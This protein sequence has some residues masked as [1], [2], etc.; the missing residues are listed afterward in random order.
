MVNFVTVL[1]NFVNEEPVI[2]FCFLYVSTLFLDSLYHMRAS[3]RLG[4]TKSGLWFNAYHHFIYQKSV[5]IIELSLYILTVLA[6]YVMVKPY[7]K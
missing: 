2:T 1:A 7:I 4:R 3:S 5:L 6:L